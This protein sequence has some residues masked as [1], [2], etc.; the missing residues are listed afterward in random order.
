MRNLLA[1]LALVPTLASAQPV[2]VPP[3]AVSAADVATP[4]PGTRAPAP[5]PTWSIGAGISSSDYVFFGSNVVTPSYSGGGVVVLGGA[6]YPNSSGA[7]IPVVNASL[8]HAIGER[9]WLVI[10]IAGAAE[11][12]GYDSPQPPSASGFVRH[13]VSQRGAIELG[14]R[15]VATPSDAF[16]TV[17]WLGTVEAGLAH[18]RAEVLYAGQSTVYEP[19]W[20]ARYLAGTFGIAVERALG[21]RLAVRIGT[22]LV[23]VTY[24]DNEQR[25]SNPSA[26]AITKGNTVGIS[27]VVAPRL[28]LRVYF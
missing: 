19:R 8:E 9:T 3:A 17:S 22:P 7:A 10:G 2:D 25:S 23:R 5:P 6:A 14:V 11:A 24:A 21:D 16:V 13:V 26:E 1:L 4:P 12:D 18:T 27:A 20:E 15:G 28:E